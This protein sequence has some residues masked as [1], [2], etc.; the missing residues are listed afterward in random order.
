MLPS[1]TPGG[2]PGQIGTRPLFVTC[3]V[4]GEL[5]DVWCVMS[6]EGRVAVRNARGT[7]SNSN[8][9]L[10]TGAILVGVLFA[11]ACSSSDTPGLNTPGG[12]QAAS[13]GSSPSAPPVK[14]DVT[15]AGD[16]V[17]PVNPVGVKATGGTLDSVTVTNSA[18]GTKVKG[19]YS[20]DKTTRTSSE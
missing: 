9:L 16:S 6:G 12:S 11:G 7:M 4:P 18:K 13:G 3:D 14:V 19:D 15:P 1:D 8:K 5:F 10:V 17:S 20:A 2:A